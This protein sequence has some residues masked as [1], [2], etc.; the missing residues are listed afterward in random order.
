MNTIPLFTTAPMVHPQPHLN[1]TAPEAAWF[2]EQ[3]ERL[4][5]T[6]MQVDIR[7]TGHHQTTAFEPQRNF[8]GPSSSAVDTDGVT[9][10]NPECLRDY[11]ATYGF[12]T[13]PFDPTI[14]DTSVELATLDTPYLHILSDHTPPAA[15]FSSRVFTDYNF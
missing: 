9:I 13:Y 10:F 11:P 1:H 7:P 12:P 2:T 8:G 5:E 14:L 15:G 3:M 6:P 4:S